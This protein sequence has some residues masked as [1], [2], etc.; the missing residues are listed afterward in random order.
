MLPR[1]D[2]PSRDDAR[3]TIDAPHEDAAIAAEKERRHTHHRRKKSVSFTR[4]VMLCRYSCLLSDELT[5]MPTRH[6]DA[7]RQARV[8]RCS[9]E[10]VD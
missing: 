8:L 1:H 10:G 9:H 5:D 3:Q 6:T 4:A 2:A 7:R